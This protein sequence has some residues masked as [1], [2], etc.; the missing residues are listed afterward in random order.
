MTSGDHK[1]ISQ[2][3]FDELRQHFSEPEILALGWRIAMFVG[4]GRLSAALGL[5]D[6][7]RVCPLTAVHGERQIQSQI[8]TRETCSRISR[9]ACHRVGFSL[10]PPATV[11]STRGST[12]FAGT[13]DKW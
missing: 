12:R 13:Y 3:L 7:G 2:D 1:Q 6:V 5:D 10:P 9:L 8:G 4:L 11:Q